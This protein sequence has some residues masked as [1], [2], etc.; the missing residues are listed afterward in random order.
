M[1]TRTC[2]VI[3]FAVVHFDVMQA[4]C[5]NDGEVL[6]ACVRMNTAGTGCVAELDTESDLSQASWLKSNA[7]PTLQK[8][9]D[10]YYKEG[11]KNTYLYHVERVMK[12]IAYATSLAY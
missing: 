11:L 6:M 7:G 2:S 10:Q 8:V 1:R 4:I 12:M 5:M 9:S 3:T